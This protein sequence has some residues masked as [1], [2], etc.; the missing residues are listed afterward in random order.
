MNIFGESA[1]DKRDRSLGL[2]GLLAGTQSLRILAERGIAS[3]QDIEISIEGIK[4]VL[5]GVPANTLDAEMLGKFDALLE[6]IRG[7]ALANFGK[8]R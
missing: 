8:D 2:A 5:D 3:P 4:Q 7:A 6:S 1:T